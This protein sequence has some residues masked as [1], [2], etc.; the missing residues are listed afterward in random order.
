MAGRIGGSKMRALLI[1]SGAFGLFNRKKVI[2]EH[3]YLTGR[4]VFQKDTVGEDMELVV[5]LQRHL[6]ESKTPFSILYQHNSNCWTEVPERWQRGLI[7]IIHFHRKM[8]FRRRYGLS[9]MA[10]FPYY[11]LFEIF[12]PLLEAQG[13][14]ALI[15]AILLGSI[16]TTILL[17]LFSA[18][19]LFGFLISLISLGLS[20]LG[21]FQFPLGDKII[22]LFTALAENLGPRQGISL[23][24]VGGFVSS[25]KRVGSWGSIERRGFNS[26]QR[27]D[28]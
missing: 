23:M 26:R 9:G 17:F 4:E 22:L 15:A 7:D 28:G 11:I 24:R 21:G 18:S 13:Y 12:G 10:A 5:R 25:L 16:D 1:I 20:E 2:E 14:T 8:I 6:L 27:G 3:G 19:I